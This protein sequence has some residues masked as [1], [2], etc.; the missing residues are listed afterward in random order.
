MLQAQQKIPSGREILKLYTYIYIYLYI[1]IQ[2]K[3]NIY[4]LC[5]NFKISLCIHIYIHTYTCVCVCVCVSVW[6]YISW[7]DLKLQTCVIIPKPDLKYPEVT[8]VFS[9]CQVYLHAYTHNLCVFFVQRVCEKKEMCQSACV[10]A[11]VCVR[12]EAYKGPHL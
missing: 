9:V 11:S 8:R 4:L 6:V 10:C 3:Q 7:L 1:Y 12:S 5:F 2:I